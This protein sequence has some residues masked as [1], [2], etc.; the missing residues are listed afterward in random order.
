MYEHATNTAIATFLRS[1]AT[2]LS[3]GEGGFKARAY[4]RV[5]D[6]IASFST[7]VTAL[8]VSG[9]LK[10]LEEIP[11][12]GVS[13]AER[14]EE[15]VTGG[16]SP[17]LDAL[18]KATP[19]DADELLAIEGLGPQR[20]FALYH[21]LGV[22]T[23]AD[24]ARVAGQGKVRDLP[25]FG[26]KTEEKILKG[27]AF[28]ARAGG[29]F[30]IGNIR[31]FMQNLARELAEVSGVE[32]VTIAGSLRRWKETIGDGDI[33]VVSNSGERVATFL[34]TLGGVRD[35]IASGETK[36]SIVFEN[37][38]HVDIRVVREESYG[39]A[40]CY[41]TGSKDHNVALRSIAQEKGMKL[42][43]YG[44][45]RGETVVHGKTEEGIYKALGLS[46]VPPELR[47]ESGEVAAA[48]AGTLPT[49][50]AYDDLRGDCQVQTSWSDGEHSIE[51]MARAA[52]ARGLSYIVITDHTKHL[53]VAHG[54]DEKR[55]KAQGKEIDAVNKK[56]VNKGVTCTVL[57][58]T[59]CDILKD[60]SL[61]LSDDALK[62]LDV[63]G[64]SVHSLFSLPQAAQTERV[65]RAMRNPFV[66]ILFHPTGR[67]LGKRDAYAIDMDAIIACAKETGTAL[68]VDSYP[69]RLDL[70]DTHIRAAVS[71]GVTL[72]I[73]SDAHAKEHF[74][75]LEY[76]VA[77]ARRGWAKR[78]DV[79]NAWPLETMRSLL[80]KKDK[81]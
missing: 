81:A 55:L 80:K 22:R 53:T 62:K 3:F 14:I 72:M 41:F 35:I 58:G 27:I 56:L 34:K 8:Y 39:A 43:E 74:T 40:L 6:T 13:I 70:C 46:Y 31:P 47:E 44:L 54:L 21:A 15:F 18:K 1:I 36:T 79:A 67:V 76:G 42:N 29:R 73:D 50:I 75:F 25:G 19:I 71:A 48:R 20:V 10:A 63:V 64:V 32:R 37:N 60:G 68:E 52:A 45:F 26:I 12:V 30:P 9:G 11:G 78:T 61:D 49:V 23:V 57:K 17:Y 59:E 28:L 69:D 24:L 2:Y 5:A 7:S 77:T 51:E 16:Q 66:D 33:L 65:C 4:V 38:M